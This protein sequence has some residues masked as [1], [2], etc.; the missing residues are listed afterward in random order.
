MEGRQS[1]M[2]AVM[3]GVLATLVAAIY[4]LE[5]PEEDDG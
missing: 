4:L 5:P 3:S 2:L 1:K